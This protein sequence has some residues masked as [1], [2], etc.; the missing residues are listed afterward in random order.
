[1]RSKR[2]FC[3]VNAYTEAMKGIQLFCSRLKE[4]RKEKKLSARELAEKLSV[5]DSTI[6]RWENGTML[7]TIDK[8]YELAAFFGVSAD[9]LLGLEE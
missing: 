5:H 1:M 8:L 9:F 6:I 3:C 2:S 7:P 4:L